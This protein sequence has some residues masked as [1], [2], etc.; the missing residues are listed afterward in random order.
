[1]CNIKNIDG[2]NYIDITDNI[3]T[4]EFRWKLKDNSDFEYTKNHIKIKLDIDW[5]EPGNIMKEE[6]EQTLNDSYKYLENK[7]GLNKVGI[8]G[9]LDYCMTNST[10][11]K[12]ATI[13]DAELFFK[14]RK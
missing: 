12:P 14:N 10:L 2:K 7:F 5:F 13:E 9:M 8:K 3:K 1:M 11:Y 4:E 6:I